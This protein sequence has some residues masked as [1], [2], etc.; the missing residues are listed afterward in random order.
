[1]ALFLFSQFTPLY[2][3]NQ[4]CAPLRPFPIFLAIWSDDSDR[5]RLNFRDPLDQTP[6][7]FSFGLKNKPNKVEILDQ[8]RE[9]S[10]DGLTRSSIAPQKRGNRQTKKE[11]FKGK[12]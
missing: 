9:K 7:K 4:N 5:F 2:E 8:L 11:F 1:M 6:L 3:H 10:C 12:V